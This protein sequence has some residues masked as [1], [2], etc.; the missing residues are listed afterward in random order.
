[1]K[2]LHID[3][4]KLRSMLWGKR[5]EVAEHLGIMPESLSRKLRTG[6]FTVDELNKIAEALQRDVADFVSIEEVETLG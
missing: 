3:I 6:Y 4:G 5:Q 1:M 2:K